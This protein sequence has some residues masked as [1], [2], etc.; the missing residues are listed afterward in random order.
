MFF[1]CFWVSQKRN[2]KQSPN[3]IKPSQWFFLDQKTHVGLGLQVRRAWSRR[4]ATG[5]CPRGEP[6]ALWPTPTPP[7]LI[8]RPIYSRIF[9]NLQKH[10][11]K[12][13]STAATFCTREIP[14]GDL[15]RRSAG[16]GFDHGGPLHQPCCPSDD[17]WVV[18]HRPTGPLLV[19]KPADL[20]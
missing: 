17:A 19:S 16:G 6:P 8:I 15:F 14:S 9:P 3:G 11:R 12:H 7:D 18:Y 1:P 4:Q 20:G 13:F 2:T 10:L 5:A